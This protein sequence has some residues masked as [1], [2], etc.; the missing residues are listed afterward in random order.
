MNHNWRKGTIQ[1]RRWQLFWIF[2]TP[3][4]HVCSFF[5]KYYPSAILTTIGAPLS[6]ADVVYGRPQIL[7]TAKAGWFCMWN[8]GQ[9]FDW[10]SAHRI[11]S[12]SKARCK[13]G[14]G[15]PIL[16]F[17]NFPSRNLSFIF[18]KLHNSLFLQVVLLEALVLP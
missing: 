10:N 4:L 11:R 12:I 15:H 2:D 16:C 1:K 8:S 7:F 18:W 6:I 5:S 9:N 17:A 14:I 3:L 13:M